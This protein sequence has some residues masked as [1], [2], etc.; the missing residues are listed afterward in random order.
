MKKLIALALVATLIFA[1]STSVYALSDTVS[2]NFRSYVNTSSS[3]RHSSETAKLYFFAT[4]NVYTGQ[5]SS[6]PVESSAYA[7]TF[8]VAVLGSGTSQK[9]FGKAISWNNKTAEVGSLNTNTS[10]YC[11]FGNYEEQYYIRGSVTIAHG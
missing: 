4:A 7:Q 6:I 8:K 5:Y 1:F 11:Q 2:V 9:S 10:Y 3:Y